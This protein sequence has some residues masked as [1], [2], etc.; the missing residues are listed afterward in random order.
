MI[1][2]VPLFVV[3]HG[4]TQVCNDSFMVAVNLPLP[5]NMVMCVDGPTLHNNNSYWG[6]I[7]NS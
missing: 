3:T 1:D 4:R 5:C 6:C 7:A 2:Q